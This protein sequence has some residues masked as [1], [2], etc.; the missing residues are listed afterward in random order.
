MQRGYQKYFKKRLV[1]YAS[2]I[3]KEQLSKGPDGDDYELTEVYII[4]LLE[5]NLP[6]NDRNRYL[7]TIS[8]MDTEVPKIFYDKLAYKLI[9]LTGVLKKI[10]L[11][12]IR[13]NPL[14]KESAEK[15]S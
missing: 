7:Y 10:C 12:S 15:P 5:F 1:Y 3:I 11:L 4:C 9:E 14:R 13:I 6:D 2:T 8:L